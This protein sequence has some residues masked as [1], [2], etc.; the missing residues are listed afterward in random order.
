MKVFKLDS[1][2]ELTREMVREYGSELSLKERVAA[3]SYGIGHLRLK[4]GHEAV[5][6]FY[7][8]ENNTIKTH[9]DW[10]KKGAVIRMRT[11]RDIYAIGLTDEQITKIELIKKPDYI[12][13]IPFTPFWVLLKLGVKVSTAK[14]FR[15]SPE[16]FN[17][18]PIIIRFNLTDE[19]NLV[20]EQPGDLWRDC[21]STFGVKRLAEKVI[22]L[23]ER[24]YEPKILL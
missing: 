21:L 20:Y 6:R 10:T 19:G 1:N 17:Y 13:A 2:G 7:N 24:S 16:K 9:F 18:G 5:M 23:D 11:S 3:K 8:Q 15:T 14:M 12:Y 22:I 4:E